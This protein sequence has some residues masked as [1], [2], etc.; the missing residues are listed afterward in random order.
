MMMMKKME[1]PCLY[2]FNTYY[3]RLRT[4]HISGRFAVGALEVVEIHRLTDK[5]T[6]RIEMVTCLQFAMLAHLHHELIST[7]IAEHAS[8]VR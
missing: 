7:F 5:E 3:T 2:F 6:S 4:R 1:M 8:A